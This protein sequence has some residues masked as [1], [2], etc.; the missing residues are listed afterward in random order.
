MNPLIFYTSTD[1]KGKKDSTYVFAPE[2][3]AFARLHGVSKDR[4]IPIPQNISVIQRRKIFRETCKK[5][6][7]I[8]KIIYFGHGSKNSLPGIGM[9][10]YNMKYCVDY[11]EGCAADQL[12]IVLYACLAGKNLGIADKLYLAL[13]EHLYCCKVVAHLTAGHSSKNPYAEYSGIGKNN[14]GQ[15]IVEKTDPLW[16]TWMKELKENQ[17]FRLS[18]PFWTKERIYDY[19]KNS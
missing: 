9:N 8:D 15:N 17:G 18:F 19:L 4:L 1:R 6:S 13:Q 11:I 10:L 14:S 12:T 7:D 3:K 5:Y 16:K 2:A